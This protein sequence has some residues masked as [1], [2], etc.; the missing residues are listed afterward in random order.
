MAVLP[1]FLTSSGEAFLSSLVLSLALSI[2]IIGFTK[3]EIDFY[4]FV[5]PV[6]LDFA[7]IM[8]ILNLLQTLVDKM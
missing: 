4:V 5:I 3:R 7:I 8:F 2:K 6:M 1:D